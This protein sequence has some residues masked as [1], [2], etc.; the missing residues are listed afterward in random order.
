MAPPVPHC[1]VSFIQLA[2][3]SSVYWSND[4]DIVGNTYQLDRGGGYS[5]DYQTVSQMNQWEKS[6]GTVRN[7]DLPST[8]S[9]CKAKKKKTYKESYT[10]HLALSLYQLSIK[11]YTISDTGRHNQTFDGSF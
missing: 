11:Y 7:I 5:L 6:I 1:S 10:L 8:L 3:Y 9:F 2:P 4:S